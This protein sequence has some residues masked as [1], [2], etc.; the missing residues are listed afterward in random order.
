VFTRRIKGIKPYAELWDI[1]ML[2]G[3]LSPIINKPLSERRQMIEN[4]V[5]TGEYVTLSE[6]VQVGKRKLF[7]MCLD[8]SQKVFEGIVLKNINSKYLVSFNKSIDHP[9][10]F[11]VRR[12]DEH[13][14]VKEAV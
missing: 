13:M 5:T 9:Q 2:D 1:I 8:Y 10:W 3:E 6:W 7:E 4:V 12:V 11:K 14:L